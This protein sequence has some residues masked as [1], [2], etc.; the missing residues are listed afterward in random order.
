M[1]AIAASEAGSQRSSNNGK[2]EWFGK[3]VPQ[4]EIIFFCQVII[5]YGVIVAA[6]VNLSI[7]NGDHVLWT[8]LLSSCLGYLLPSPSLKD[9]P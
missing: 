5:I 8:A 6:I 1:E 2:W 7:Q 3:R 4:R 9:K